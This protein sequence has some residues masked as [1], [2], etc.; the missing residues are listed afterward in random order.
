MNVNNMGSVPICM[1]LEFAGK[2]A[3]HTVN[4]AR[5]GA[6]RLRKPVEEMKRSPLHFQA[7]GVSEE[8]ERLPR[9]KDAGTLLRALVVM[10]SADSGISAGYMLANSSVIAGPSV[11]LASQ[12][13][14]AAG[15]ILTYASRHPAV[16]PSADEGA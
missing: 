8:L 6:R 5:E 7:V 1:I 9:L 15:K 16:P 2:F 10:S 3:V 14:E 4:G 13:P 12:S 11:A